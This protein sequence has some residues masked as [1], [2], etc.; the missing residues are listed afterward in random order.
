MCS[1][2][3]Q[4]WGVD[5]QWLEAESLN[6]TH[7]DADMFNVCFTTSVAKTTLIRSSFKCTYSQHVYSYQLD[8]LLTHS[9]IF[10]P[11]VSSSVGS[12]PAMFQPVSALYLVYW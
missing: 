7:V 11:P 1:H 9:L 4:L 8:A 3:S 5:L 12:S 2:Q 6:R 10:T